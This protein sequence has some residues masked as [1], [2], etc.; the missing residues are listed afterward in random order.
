MVLFDKGFKNLDTESVTPFLSA[1]VFE[2]V[3]ENYGGVIE[4]LNITNMKIPTISGYFHSPRPGNRRLKV[5]FLIDASSSSIILTPQNLEIIDDEIEK[6]YRF[7]SSLALSNTSRTNYFPIEYFNFAQKQMNCAIGWSC[8]G[9]NGYACLS[10]TKKNC[11]NNLNSTHSEYI[12]WL[13]KNKSAESSLPSNIKI[14]ETPESNNN[15]EN[16]KWFDNNILGVR[17]E[18]NSELLQNKDKLENNPNSKYAIRKIKEISEKQDKLSAYEKSDKDISLPSDYKLHQ[19]TDLE[20]KE[21]EGRLLS[22]P[23]SRRMVALSSVSDELQKQYP[24]ITKAE[25]ASLKVYTQTSFDHMN[26]YLRTDKDSDAI[27]KIDIMK[28]GG[29]YRP[30][31]QLENDTIADTR[32]TTSA[33]NKLPD[34]VGTVL[35]GTKMPKNM[36]NSDIENMYKPGSTITEKSFTSTS[37]SS[38]LKFRGELQYVIESKTGKDISD[39]SDSRQEKEILFRPNANFNVTGFKKTDSGYEIRLEEVDKPTDT[40]NKQVIDSKKLIESDSIQDILSQGRD[41]SSASEKSIEDNISNKKLRTRLEDSYEIHDIIL[42]KAT[43]NEADTHFRAIKDQ[44]NI[45]QSVCTYKKDSKNSSIILK[46]L[47]S[48]PWNITGNE[49]K[50]VKGTGTELILSLA[51]ESKKLGYGGRIILTPTGDSAGF[52]DKLG[53]TK[54][55]YDGSEFLELKPEAAANLLKK[56]GKIQ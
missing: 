35:R 18:L 48:A 33:L 30:K 29:E 3:D 41:W 55:N 45:I 27:Y 54:V 22:Q 8:K 5:D 9:E 20:S 15:G 23:N 43:K 39:I 26:T 46:L 51:Q 2:I 31:Y 21:Y 10:K 38:D 14:K 32:M 19:A 37:S 16:K 11:N 52:Y 40:K 56:T 47:A 7:A 42:S 44:N 50:S 4:N 28:S 12:Q 6:R 34:F 13:A 53:F 25:L 24:D 36:S 1:L 49:E 17:K